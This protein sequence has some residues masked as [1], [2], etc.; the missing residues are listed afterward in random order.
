MPKFID[1]SSSKV[2]LYQILQNVSQKAIQISRQIADLAVSRTEQPQDNS[3]TSQEV[4][5]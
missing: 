4:Q 1:L 3:M 2:R 5:I